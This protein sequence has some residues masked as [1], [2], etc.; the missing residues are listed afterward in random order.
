MAPVSAH[1]ELISC[2]IGVSLVI[3]SPMKFLQLCLCLCI[4]ALGASRTCAQQSL[5][6]E[7]RQQAAEALR[8]ALGQAPSTAPAETKPALPPPPAE[9]IPTPT[10]TP[11]PTPV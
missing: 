5:T 4:A 9:T 8:K 2:F 7:Q 3:L 10:P 6:P 1:I 11:A